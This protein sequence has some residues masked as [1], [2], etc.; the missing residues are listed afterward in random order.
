M[1]YFTNT[2]QGKKTAKLCVEHFQKWIDRSKLVHCLE[3]FMLR[4]VSIF[5]SRSTEMI[6]S[7]K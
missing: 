5:N 2:H 7:M 1:R 3:E 6:Q 4:D